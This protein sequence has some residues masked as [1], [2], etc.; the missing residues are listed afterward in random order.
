MFVMHSDTGRFL[1]RFQ[2]RERWNARDSRMGEKL[3]EEEEEG[4]EEGYSYLHIILDQAA[5]TALLS[6]LS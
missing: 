4:A 5:C 2:G 6:I 1:G 3:R